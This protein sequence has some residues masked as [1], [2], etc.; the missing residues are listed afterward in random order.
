MSKEC[1]SH[2]WMYFDITN[3]NAFNPELRRCRTCMRREIREHNKPWTFI[4]K[5]DLQQY[6]DV[7]NTLPM[8]CSE[9]ECSI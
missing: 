4:T 2:S 9:A 7:S 3:H 6:K 5:E 8:L 1:T